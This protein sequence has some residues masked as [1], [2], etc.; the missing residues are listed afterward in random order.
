MR[1][2][3]LLQLEQ[4]PSSFAVVKCFPFLGS[5]WGTRTPSNYSF[6]RLKRVVKKESWERKTESLA[7]PS[8]LALASLPACFLCCMVHCGISL[9]A[10]PAGRKGHRW[11]RRDKSPL[12]GHA[13]E[14]LDAGWVRQGSHTGF[15]AMSPCFCFCPSFRVPES[16]NYL[17][18]TRS[19]GFF[20]AML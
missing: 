15:R 13:P 8:Q 16:S 18:P 20:W 3:C 4:F 7:W 5:Y 9:G 2:M 10:R 19:R 11:G 14:A 12:P 1:A 17:A 6:T